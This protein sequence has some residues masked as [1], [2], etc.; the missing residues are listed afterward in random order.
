MLDNLGLKESLDTPNL[1]HI[2]IKVLPEMFKN[3]R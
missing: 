2:A 3:F 1:I